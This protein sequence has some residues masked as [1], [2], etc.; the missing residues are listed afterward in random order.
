[1]V[2]KR[3]RNCPAHEMHHSDHPAR[4]DPRLRSLYVVARP[5]RKTGRLKLS[6]LSQGS[7][8][9]CHWGLFVSPYNENELLETMLQQSE[10][11]PEAGYSGLGTLVELQQTQHGNK[12]HVV[13]D[14]Q[15]CSWEQ[16]VF[17]F[18]GGTEMSDDEIVEHGMKVC[19]SEA[20]F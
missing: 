13:N 15:I 16:A 9:F 14:F 4:R 12:P 11:I 19:I 5:I 18:V 3:R 17:A 2:R 8:P 1:M 7:F 10:S 6:F 20:D